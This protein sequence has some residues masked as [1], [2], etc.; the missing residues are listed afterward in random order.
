MISNSFG[1][2]AEQQMPTHNQS[3][4]SENWNRRSQ[5]ELNTDIRAIAYYGYFTLEIVGQI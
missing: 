1:R 2:V 4:W 5:D 3:S